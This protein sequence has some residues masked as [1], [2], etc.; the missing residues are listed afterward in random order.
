MIFGVGVMI[1]VCF[2]RLIVW[3]VSNLSVVSVWRVCF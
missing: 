3:G 2:C 1:V